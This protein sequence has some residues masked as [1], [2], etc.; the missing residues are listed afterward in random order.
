LGY[1]IEDNKSYVVN[2]ADADIVLRIYVKYLAG[3]TMAEI[4]RYFNENQVKTL[5]GKPYSKN[6]L[7]NVLKNR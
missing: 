1:D 7:R 5:R 3:S 2:E 4:I 6:S